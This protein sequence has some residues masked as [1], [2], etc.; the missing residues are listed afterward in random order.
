MMKSGGRAVKT[1]LGL[2]ILAAIALSGRSAMAATATFTIS[3]SVSS[4]DRGYAQA[5]GVAYPP[6]TLS[7]SSAG[8]V[9]VNTEVWGGSY[10]RRNGLLRFETGDVLDGMTPTAARLTFCT[11]PYTSAADSRVVTAD[12][13]PLEWPISTDD[14]SA[15][16]LTTALASFDYHTACT[17][18]QRCTITFDNVTGI[19]TDADTQD[20]YTHVRLHMSGGEPAGVNMLHLDSNPARCGEDAD[21]KLEVD[22]TEPEVT[23]TPTATLAASYT[24]TITKTPTV[25]RTP[26]NTVTALPTV[27]PTVTA[28][29]IVGGALEGCIPRTDLVFAW[30]ADS[31]TASDSEPVLSWPDVG[32]IGMNPW[33][34][35]SGS[36]PLYKADVANGHPAVRFAGP[37]SPRYM[38]VGSATYRLQQLY[39]VYSKADAVWA[40]YTGIVQAT[41]KTYCD[42]VYTSNSELGLVGV[43]NT[44]KINGA[45]C[46]DQTTSP[47]TNAWIDGTVVYS[48]PNFQSYLVGIDQGDAT[49]IHAVSI[50]YANDVSGTKSWILGKAAW[51]PATRAF[52]GDLF[53]VLGYSSLHDATTRQSVEQCIASK[54]ALSWMWTPTPTPTG[55]WLTST[56]TETYTSGP[57]H[58]PTATH[59]PTNGSP[60]TTRTPTRTATR[61]VTGGTPTTTPN[62]DQLVPPM[63]WLGWY[64]FNQSANDAYI[65]AIADE[66]ISHGLDVAGYKIVALDEGWVQSTRDA[67]GNMQPTASFPNMALLSA[68]IHGLGLKMGIYTDRGNHTC[69]N[70]GPG[71]YGHAQQDVN[72]FASWNIDSVKLDNCGVSP[73]P[74]QVDVADFRTAIGN[75]VRP[76]MLL[77]I[78]HTGPTV[79]AVAQMPQWGDFW[80]TGCNEGQYYESDSCFIQ[81]GGL[82][83]DWKHQELPLIDNHQLSRALTRPGKFN[84]LDAI[85]AARVGVGDMTGSWYTETEVKSQMA[86]R[87]IAASPLWLSGTISNYTANEFTI[88]T[89]EEVIA[90]NQDSLAIQGYTLYSNG[91]NGVGAPK[92][93]AFYK[94]LS[95]GSIAVV[96]LNRTDA[97]AT[98]VLTFAD[99]GMTGS[100]T[101]RD[102]WAK[103]DVGTYTTSYTATAI[104]AHDNVMLKLTGSS[105]TPT[106]TRTATRTSAVATRTPTTQVLP[107]A[108]HTPTATS[109]PAPTRAGTPCS[110]G[111]QSNCSINKGDVPIA[112]EDGRATFGFFGPPQLSAEQI[113]ELSP[114]NGDQV[115]NVTTNKVQVYINGVWRN[116]D[117]S[118]P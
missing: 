46:G 72:L 18:E 32:S 28:T 116:M 84:D 65:R 22:Y 41:D 88:L 12:W 103:S 23:N 48:V 81:T 100:V 15:S 114:S 118:A 25:S 112:G 45:Q 10:T 50:A 29:P 53:M 49:G 24:P 21:I 75:S 2:A 31:I 61:T 13:G 66:F 64:G 95:D 52:N 94:P 40:D 55:T 5:T 57:T 17:I 70:S 101:V 59:T 96:L 62:P 44:N 77:Y 30:S 97:P 107:A 33:Q 68:Y 43:K 117:D 78:A 71:S 92:G 105:Y 54:Y 51:G 104:P 58:T 76:R 91:V 102:L 111:E 34:P 19:V 27:T 98:I 113:G 47:A 7:A 108:T 63:G 20:G 89:N 42:N 6:E 93:Y 82:Y 38:V 39:V 110:I 1:F 36:A 60:T 109:T 16:V 67:S 11:G 37:S 14:Y 99:L 80:L 86:M 74:W 115:Y 83:L 90:V 26:T 69:D 3:A 79:D 85:L 4:T 9:Y 106:V 73:N 35:V 56:P 8:D 87:A